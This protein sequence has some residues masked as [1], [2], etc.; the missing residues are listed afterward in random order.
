M[1]TTF[2][3]AL[4]YKDI[5]TTPVRFAV[6]GDVFP[7]ATYL[8]TVNGLSFD[9][10][11]NLWL[12]G[13][14]NG[15]GRVIQIK[16]ASWATDGTVTRLN[17]SNANAQITTGVFSPWGLAFDS[18]GSLWVVNQ[19]DA[20]GTGPGSL[21]RYTAGSLTSNPNPALV[22]PQSARFALGI[23]IASP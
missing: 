12:S 18:A 14:L 2:G 6:I 7:G 5:T 15:A 10:T 20:T 1:T 22:V 17:A 16:A 3:F 13:D 4:G 8:N 19:T 23:A 9:A 21:A 11:G